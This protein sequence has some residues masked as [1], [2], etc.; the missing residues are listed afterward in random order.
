[1]Q[2]VRSIRDEEI[3]L[4]K[5]LLERGFEKTRILAYFTHPDRPVNF[6]RIT[7][8]ERGT[9][10]PEVAVA[11][12][13]EVDRSL[14]KW[15][16]KRGFSVE[17]VVETALDLA[18]LPPTDSR[19]LAALFEKR[20][21]SSWHLISGE[22]DEVECKRS[23]NLGSKVLRA[24]AALANN[25]GGYILFGVANENLSWACKALLRTSIRTS[26][27]SRLERSWS[28]CLVSKRGHANW[29]D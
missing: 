13:S 1:M 11:T 26:F 27:R 29:T 16:E 18:D 2:R 22:T 20:G 23:F 15:N 3:A 17:A 21:N 25:R 4:I 12:P 6:G 19:K 8:I 24:V 28:L 7:N 5:G 14:E 9:Y 10:G